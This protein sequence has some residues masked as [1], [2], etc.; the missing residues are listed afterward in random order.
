MMKRDKIKKFISTM[1]VTV[2]CVVL[3]SCGVSSGGGNVNASSVNG[4]GI[5]AILTISDASDAFRSTLAA[6]AEQA[7]GQCGMELEVLDAA[8][9]SETQ[10]NHIKQA[11]DA[12]VIIC[13]LCDSGTAQQMEALAGDKPIVFI[14]SCPDE[15]YLEAN[16]YV[17]VGSDEGVAGGLQA[18]YVLDKFSSKDTLNVA[19]IKG[20]STHS[21][22][23]GR[24]KANKAVLEA[25]G[26]T[27]NYV[28]EDYADWSTE[29]AEN[30]FDLFLKTKQPIDA[31]LCNND[32]M[33]IGIVQSMEKNG[34]SFDSVP[35][36]GVDATSDGLA[37]IEAGKL[38]CTIFQPAEGQG[39]LAVAAAVQL[40]KGENL[41][42]LEGAE[43]NNLYA[44]VS[45]EQVT[46]SNVGD[47]K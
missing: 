45:F 40:V 9:S 23:K 39:K 8:G 29:I 33:A 38:A 14:N 42:S 16:K 13:A 5:K 11:T 10:M 31:V 12:D 41:S 2:L 43:D 30:M 15:D 36:L 37:S 6:A 44:W 25:S 21:A 34:I 24:T 22:T 26:K 18:E 19:I 27:I 35:V 3:T 7:A 17:Y 4:K 1:L 47:Y 28:Y 46:K 20:E 32:S